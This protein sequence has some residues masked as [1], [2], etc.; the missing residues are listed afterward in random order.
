MQA[1][2]A[3]ALLKDHLRSLSG[4]E[5]AAVI[6]LLTETRGAGLCHRGDAPEPLFL[7]LTDEGLR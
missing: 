3:R 1:G 6:A 7:E 5:R 2:R 4:D